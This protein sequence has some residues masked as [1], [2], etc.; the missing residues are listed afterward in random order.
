M[1]A[2]AT[3]VKD[4][5]ALL[6]RSVC[7]SCLRACLGG[8]REVGA[9]RLGLACHA[10]LAERWS[11]RRGR[12]DAPT[13]TV[14]EWARACHALVAERLSRRRGRADAPHV[15]AS[16]WSRRPRGWAQPPSRCEWLPNSPGGA[17]PPPT[18]A[19]VLGNSAG[20]R[21]GGA[22]T[23]II[24]I[25]I[26]P[27]YSTSRRKPFH[28][29]NNVPGIGFGELAPTHAWGSRWGNTPAHAYLCVCSVSERFFF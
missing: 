21:G 8:V 3:I 5:R 28:T 10:L 11:R 13:V 16:G 22:P 2:T 25:R 17:P 29:R 18:V 23:R 27:G 15:T 1:C 24:S 7:C 12:S 19:I 9:G 26:E 6:R 20:S 14:R 4:H